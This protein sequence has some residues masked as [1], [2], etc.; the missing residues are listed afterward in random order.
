MGETCFWDVHTLSKGAPPPIY[1]CVHQPGR[2]LNF[3]LS[4][5]FSYGATIFSSLAIDSAFSL[6]PKLEDGPEGSSCRQMTDFEVT[7]NL[8][9]V[10][11]K[12]Q[13]MN[14]TK[15]ITRLSSLRKLE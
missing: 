1:G 14:M 5:G 13:F 15:N 9:S 4:Q 11:S 2:S 7:R 10:F 3:L 8:Y 6:S 12:R